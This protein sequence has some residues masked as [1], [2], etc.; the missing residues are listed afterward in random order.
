MKTIFLGKPTMYF[1]YPKTIIILD[2]PILIETIVYSAVDNEGTYY[3]LRELKHIEKNPNAIIYN[4]NEYYTDYFNNY[5][6]MNE[7]NTDHLSYYYE[8]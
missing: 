3:T 8:V 4:E 1:S 7:I 5:D 2:Q 6:G